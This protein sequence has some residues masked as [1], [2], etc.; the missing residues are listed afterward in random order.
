[1]KKGFVFIVFILFTLIVSGQGKR[2]IIKKDGLRLTYDLELVEVVNDACSR[3]LKFVSGDRYKITVYLANES[4]KKLTSTGGY[5]PMVS[6]VAPTHGCHPNI[7]HIS[8]QLPLNP[9]DITKA[10]G[11]FTIVS[12][13][14]EASIQVF[15][16]L[17]RG[18]KFATENT[19][20]SYFYFI[21]ENY[22]TK[23]I[24]YANVCKVD[25]LITFEFMRV[26]ETA[27]KADYAAKYR[28]TGD[29]VLSVLFHGPFETIEQ[30]KANRSKVIKTAM[31]TSIP[32][33][34]YQCDTTFIFN[35]VCK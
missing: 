24:A 4:G 8:V 23:R 3:D 11:Y 19:E 21:G 1:M 30:A 13:K 9:G 28:S 10:S 5:V 34:N 17:L 33:Y 18:Y 22:I 26:L 29:N 2:L 15:E 7:E 31:E 12:G 16:Y 27:F 25:C 6:Y 20:P 35:P 14:P 32:K